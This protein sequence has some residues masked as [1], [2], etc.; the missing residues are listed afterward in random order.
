MKSRWNVKTGA[1]R[2]VEEGAPRAPRALIVDD[3]EGMRAY[4]ATLF[5]TRGFE[6]DT[7]N[8]GGR[9]L[10]LLEN[11]AG[12][13]VVL[14][15]VMM[16]GT[17]GLAALAQIR[18][19]WPEVPVLMVSV[20]GNANTIV[21]AMQLG[22]SDYITKPF[23]E[24]ELDAALDRIGLHSSG[25]GRATA[26]P[27]ARSPRPW[28]GRSRPRVCRSRC[29]PPRPLPCP[30]RTGR[31]RSCPCRMWARVPPLWMWPRSPPRTGRRRSPTHCPRCPGP[32]SRAPLRRG[33][34]RGAAQRS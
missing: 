11:G 10:F 1:E 9:A 21:Q 28:S 14:L 2:S 13:D 24:A 5:E 30:P 29:P 16:P 12:P 27:A 7:C 31:G 3:A 23:E 32:R 34:R 33:A 6:V 20:I 26:A 15:D 17:D 18:E 22:A 19:A 4:L 25:A 8:D